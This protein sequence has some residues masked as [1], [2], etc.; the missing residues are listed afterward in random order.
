M[1]EVSYLTYF[2]YK[3]IN[4]ME[5][6]LMRVINVKRSQERYTSTHKT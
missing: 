5:D 1:F 3:Q 6:S 4:K 2:D